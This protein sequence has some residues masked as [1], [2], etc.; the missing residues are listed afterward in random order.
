MCYDGSRRVTSLPEGEF[1]F[2]PS[3]ALGI[4]HT[5]FKANYGF[6]HEEPSDFATAN[7]IVDPDLYS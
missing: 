5:P 1:A 2:N 4:E 6:S 3:R 7:A